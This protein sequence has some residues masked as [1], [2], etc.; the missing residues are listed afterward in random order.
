MKSGPPSWPWRENR[1]PS[2]FPLSR[3]REE[4]RSALLP[5]SGRVLLL[6]RRLRKGR[7]LGDLSTGHLGPVVAALCDLGL[8]VE[9]ADFERRSF[10]DQVRAVARARVLVEVHGQAVANFLFFRPGAAAVEVLVRLGWPS[11]GPLPG[12]VAGGRAY[13]FRAAGARGRYF[14]S[15]GL[16]IARLVGARF[17]YLDSEAAEITR[18]EEGTHPTFLVNAS[19]LALLA[20][21]AWSDALEAFPR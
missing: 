9:L 6:Q 21:G 20:W 17:F 1:G 5:F 4:E 2:T 14:L 8:P 19:K 3:P 18:E 16:A 11:T 15:Y 7:S 12:G 10:Q 13:D